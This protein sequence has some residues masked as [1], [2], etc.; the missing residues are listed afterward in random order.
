VDGCVVVSE[1]AESVGQSKRWI[2]QRAKREKWLFYPKNGRG[3]KEFPVDRLPEDVRVAL[4]MQSAKRIVHS[5][6]PP[7]PPLQKGG[8]LRVYN[9]DRAIQAVGSPDL[10]DW[11]NRI[12]LARADLIRA[13]LGAEASAK[14]E[15]RSR[16]EAKKLYI[17]GYNTGH[18]LPAV[19][20]ILGP[21]ALPTVYS[22]IKAFRASNY[23]YMTLA[24]QWGNRKGDRKVTDE[25]F[26]T[27]LSFALHPNRLRIT[28][29]VR[30]TKVALG[31]RAAFS[32]SSDATLR[33]SLEDW[34]SG[35]YDRWVFC[36]EGEK[37][38][39]DKCL[40]YLER[41][42]GLLDVGEV[43]VAD[44][45]TLNFQI[46]HPFTGK[47]CRMTMIM[48]YD[49]ASAMP[50]GWEIMPTE[51]V[52]C[53]AAGLR[54]AILALGKTP[55]VAYLDNGK[56][57]K[58]K[59]FTNQSI[60]FEEAGFYGMFAR[61]GIET[62][63]A[64]PYNAQSKPI[65]RFFGTF[66]E[67]ERLMPTY[68]GASIQD[69]PAHM[70]RNEKLHRQIHEKKYGGWVPTIEEA[71]QIIGGWVG[72][73]SR[74]PHRGLKGLCPGEVFASGKG[75]G[76]DEPALRFLMMSVEI[77]T[78]HRNGV[79]FMGRN[80]YDEALYG[81][82]DR[83]MVRYDMEDLSRVL[84]Y[85]VSGARL[86]CEALPVR[87][88]HPVARIS[89]GKEDMALVKEGIRQKRGLKRET[90]MGARAYIAGSPQL[91]E[92]PRAH[93]TRHTAQGEIPPGPPLRKGGDKLIEMPRGEAEKIEAEA[94]QM[95]VLVLKPRIPDPIYMSEADRFE[96]L[97]ERECRG[98]ELGIDEM[99]FM[100]YFEKTEVFDRLKDRFEFL[101]ELWVAGDVESGTE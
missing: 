41:D 14:K 88:V 57:F 43:L 31:R 42:A 9:K 2:N 26:N 11:Q 40:P 76:V 93:G 59:I 55:R 84:V 58:A 96:A 66:N 95:K 27:L 82:R 35:N 83:V 62:I 100:R 21:V 1:I 74:R 69:K 52:Q 12:A 7:G 24:P 79:T 17:K 4:E 5:K 78:V 19:F 3:D 73:Y 22:H 20:E 23:D 101:R 28:E 32:P 85:D 18:L 77:K 47:P 97:L 37:A 39:N 61:L 25:E 68:T 38:L 71:L 15:G 13:V 98:E 70:L 60:D 80:Y 67:L 33:R 6:I 92:I 94:S 46:L 48:W 63:F 53:V 99:Q 64:W 86:I 50:A 89:G 36:R 30:L 8:E 54:R 45:H 87:A 65:E 75:P 81:M 10:A 44:G 29:A 51:N 34:K 16:V 91:V 72:E 56:A 90:E 49:W